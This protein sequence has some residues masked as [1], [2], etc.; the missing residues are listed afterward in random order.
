MPYTGDTVRVPWLV[1][2]LDGSHPAT[3]VI[4]DFT[5]ALIRNGS[6]ASE[7]VSL[8]NIGTGKYEF[9]YTGANAGVYN[10]TV[11]EGSFT[12][13][14][15]TS[16]TNS[17]VFLSAGSTASASASDAFCSQ[18]D[19]ERYV[20]RTFSSSSTPSASAVLS[21]M[22][23]V[24]NQLT[25]ICDRAGRRVTPANGDTPIGTATGT[26]VELAGMLR[27]ANALG[28]AAMAEMSGYLGAPPN[29]TG[30][31]DA[32][33]TAFIRLAGGIIPGSAQVVEGL[34]AGYIAAT[35]ASGTI[36]ATHVS[37]GQATSYAPTTAVTST[38]NVTEAT[39]W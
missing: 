24:A 31:A 16:F 3:L 4:G 28:A 9:V 22:A 11:T 7:T 17:Q 37:T 26:M 34:I 6:A 30:R 32:Y 13:S 20:G 27:E 15:G 1:T 14:A 18:A 10:L 35:F 19:V 39:Q 29:E 33:Y 38:L 12:N 2:A 5:V 21:F 36:S 8:S 23:E 25:A